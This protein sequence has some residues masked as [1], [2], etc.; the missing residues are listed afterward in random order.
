MKLED[1]LTELVG[2]YAYETGSTDSGVK[3]D[4]RRGEL[5]A[6]YLKAVEPDT[7]ET[8]DA[9]SRWFREYWLSEDAIEQG[10]GIEDAT[11]FFAWLEG[12]L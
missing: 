1:I 6:A 12:D 5:A 3:D 8:R 7:K 4:L 11:E 10:Y 2:F 9:E